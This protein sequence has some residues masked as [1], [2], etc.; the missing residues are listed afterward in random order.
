MFVRSGRWQVAGSRLRAA[1]NGAGSGG[2]TVGPPQQGA[3]GPDDNKALAGQETGPNGQQ[4]AADAPPASWDEVFQHDRFK[5]LVKRAKEAEAALEKTA[6]DQEAAEAAK[7]KEQQRYEE[8]YQKAEAKAAE[9]E[10]RLTETQRATLNERKRRAVEDAARTHE[11]AF[12][13][14]A[15][16]D[17]MV[18][19]DL[20][21]L[22]VGEDGA[23]KGV[24]AAVKALAKEKPYMLEQKRTD[25]GSPAGRKTAGAPQPQQRPGRP[26]TL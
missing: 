24:E 13:K 9:L 7:L 10:Q 21:S 19:V 2:G 6:R 18:F 16:A 17:V 12:S 25:P 15:L 1:D 23:V 4:R 8:L 22:E 11:P 3:A 20:E 14:E 26:L 5:Q